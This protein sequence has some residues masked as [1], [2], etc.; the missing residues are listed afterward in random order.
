[1]RLQV[2]TI[3]IEQK[4]AKVP[5]LA[6]KF[7]VGDIKPEKQAH[8][9]TLHLEGQADEK[10]TFAQLDAFSEL[11]QTK[12]IDLDPKHRTSGGCESCVQTEANIEVVIYDAKL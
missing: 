5:A 7:Y 11:F 1:M 2:L 3:L 8:H 6:G 9:Y 12:K 10:V 4:L